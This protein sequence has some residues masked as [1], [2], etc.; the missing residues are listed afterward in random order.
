MK[1]QILFATV[2]LFLLGILMANAY[3]GLEY[4]VNLMEYLQLSSG[5]TEK[6]KA[7]LQRVSPIVYGGNISEPPLGIYN[8]ENGQY[9]GMIVDYISA[10]SIELGETIVSK[11]MIWSEALEALEDG[12]TDICDMIPSEER[13]QK[14]AFSAPIYDLNG[15][16][17][18]PIGDNRI[19]GAGELNG[20]RVV[21]QKG[22]YAIEYMTRKGIRAELTQVD[23]MSQAMLLLKAGKVDAAVGDEPVAY[24]YLESLGMESGFMV[25]DVPLYRNR[26]SLGV[27]KD[28]TELL[29]V[30]DKAVFK[31]RQKG[32]LAQIQK[33]WS[34]PTPGFYTDISADKLKLTLIGVALVFSAA[35][36]L[37]WI[38]SR[39]LKLLVGIRTRELEYTKNELQIVFDSMSSFLAVIN[40]Q[41]TII[42][43]NGAFLKA[44]KSQEDSLLGRNFA[45]IG[46][47]KSFDETQEGLLYRWMAAPENTC[48][49]EKYEFLQDERIYTARCCLLEKEGTNSVELLLMISDE[50]MSRRQEMRLIHANKMETIGILATGVAHELRNPLGIIR[51][52]GFV[53]KSLEPEDTAY[54]DLAVTAIENSV[55]RASHIID[56]LLKHSRLTDDHMDQIHLRS[57]LEEILTLFGRKME[58][59]QIAASLHCH[60]EEFLTTNGA[61]LWHGILNIIQNAVDAMPG[62][63][64][65]AV[66]VFSEQE[67]TVIQITD[68]GPGINPEL[69]DKIF[70]PFFTTKEI[71]QGTGL[72][73]YVAYSEIKK[74]GGFIHVSTKSGKGCCFS[75]RIPRGGAEYEDTNEAPC[76]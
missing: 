20:H 8:E 38:W 50:T 71:G 70:D 48:F 64:A 39:S 46:M 54:R 67:T 40:R 66:D 21:V 19:K 56:N 36:Y 10:L 62:G 15:G 42:N 35:L 6:E 47:L 16:I 41:G 27:S 58:E 4:R 3:V 31:L 2:L 63:G 12:E 51:N 37:V 28:N 59:Q 44:L 25:L 13:Q 76:C 22:D 69:L 9:T 24:H 18:V 74:A 43:I 7:V 45:D 29:N 75:I 57:F 55:T 23:N 17:I 72:G 61:S 34:S 68:N 30:L 65:L 53:L 60:E 49:E 11:P 52:S 73:L 1:R 32:I 33:K 26:V 14:Y 5:Y